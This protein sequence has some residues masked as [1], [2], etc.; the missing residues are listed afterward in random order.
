MYS[1]KLLGDFKISTAR[2]LTI[3]SPVNGI[4]DSVVWLESSLGRSFKD[5]ESYDT[6]SLTAWYDIRESVSKNSA[7]QTDTTY[8]PTYSNTINYVHAVKF[9]GTNSYLTISDASYLNNTNYTIFVLEQ[10]ESSKSSNYFIGDSSSANES[11]TNANLTL[12]YSADGTIKHSQSSDNSYT[13]S[14]STYAQSMGKPRVFSFVHDSSAGKKTYINGVLAASSSNTSNLTNMT[15]LKIGKSYKG[16]IGEI[17][18]FNRALTTEERQ[19]V[20]DYL[21][22]KWGSTILRGSTSGSCSSGIVTNDGCKLKCTVPT[23]TGITTTSV[24]DGSGSLTCNSS[25]N[26][27]GSLGYSCSSGVFSRT[28][29]ATCGCAT[30]YVLSGSSCTVSTCTVPSTTGITT[31]TVNSGSGSLTCDSA[32]NFSTAL[33]LPYTCSNGT[34]TYTGNSTCSCA[35]GYTLSGSSCVITSVSCSGGTISTPTIFG[36]SYKVHTF[37]SSGTLTCT[38]GGKADILVVAGGGGGGGDAA[39][40]GGGGGVVY[41]SSQSIASGSISITVGSGGIAG[42][43]TNATIATNGGNSSFGSSIIAIGGGAGGRYNGGSGSS[44]GS[45]G[46]GAYIGG[47]SGAG[48]SGQGNSGGSGGSS[49]AKAA[50][51]GGGGAGG[52]GVAGG[53]DSTSSYGGSGIGYSM[54]SESISYYGG[55][56]GGGRFDGSGQSASNVGNGGGG[57]GSTGCSGVSAVAGTSNTGGGGGGAAAGCQNKGAAGGSGIVVVRYAN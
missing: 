2:T 25:Q 29:S 39:G 17:I 30:G 19:S 41:K 1:S 50:G 8:S 10:R 51:G 35:D 40:G 42:V 9:D 24:E 26:F 48:T 57:Q 28:D 4:K 22:K 31:A 12:G 47:S 44:G 54:V 32:N 5:S 43:G 21:G 15:S 49:N 6:G 13:S 38:A 34:F 33:A 11:V 14:I 20:E 16:Q 56:G 27:S 23:T 37:T 45:G 52:A 3:S 36:T 53:N 46:G 18:I 55:G 7:L